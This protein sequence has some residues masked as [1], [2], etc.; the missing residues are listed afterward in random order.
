MKILII[1]DEPTTAETIKTMLSAEQA[2]CDVTLSG[3]EGFEIGKIYSYDAIILDLN[4]PDIN[5]HELLQKIRESAIR[6]PILIL[7][8]M[9]DIEEKVKALGF[10]ADDYMTKPFHRQELIARIK[11]LVR[12]SEGHVSSVIT[13]GE[14]SLNLDAKTVDVRSTPLVLTGKEYKILELLMLRRG[15]TITKEAFINYLYNGLEEPEAKIIDVFMCKI[16]KKLVDIM[17][18]DGLCYIATIW[19]RG[20]VMSD[21]DDARKHMA[22]Q[23]VTGSNVTSITSAV[24]APKI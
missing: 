5:G 9:Q 19:G 24:V 6:A 11:A 21:P 17:G 16:R 13:V 8:G 23:Q 15:T 3:E 4:L 20:Y 22:Q 10:G 14:I 1:E 2:V 18:D 7:S 12:R